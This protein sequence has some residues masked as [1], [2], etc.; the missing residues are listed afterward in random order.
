MSE[1]RLK[2]KLFEFRCYSH[3]F[4]S[5]NVPDMPENVLHI[6]PSSLWSAY[7]G[8]KDK[9]AIEEIAAICSSTFCHIPFKAPKDLINKNIETLN[10]N[11]W[12][13]SGSFA[14]EHFAIPYHSCA[15]VM[16]ILSIRC[17]RTADGTED[18]VQDTQS[19]V[20]RMHKNQRSLLASWGTQLSR[21]V[22]VCHHPLLPQL[23]TNE[24]DH[25]S[26]SACAGSEQT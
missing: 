3:L 15:E 16:P 21:E 2:S 23:C 5:M 6:R 1:L 25:Q 7:S 13:P 20:A 12:C 22:N 8:W 17:R 10:I 11:F 24:D 19:P 26:I 9:W 4:I 14:Q 18:N